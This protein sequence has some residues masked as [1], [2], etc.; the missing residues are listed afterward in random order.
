MHRPENIETQEEKESDSVE[1]TLKRHLV[2]EFLS[3]KGYRRYFSP[4]S[5]F[6]RLCHQIQ[7]PPYRT[8]PKESAIITACCIRGQGERVLHCRVTHL[9][10]IKREIKKTAA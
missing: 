7:R 1:I 4:I 9:D 6:V 3:D 5:I 10:S 8:R 2:V